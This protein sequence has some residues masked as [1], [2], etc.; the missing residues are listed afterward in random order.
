VRLNLGCGNRR[1]EGYLNLD[2]RDGWTW[3]GGLPNVAS[4]SI[5]CVTSSHTLMY[6]PREKWASVFNEIFRV[7]Q[8]GG[9]WRITEDD[10]VPPGVG[11]A[12]YVTRSLADHHLTQAG[13]T[14]AKVPRDR[15]LFHD[16]SIIQDN[17]PDELTISFWL[18]GIKPCPAK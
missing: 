4:N 15:T 5:E 16:K 2:R 9:V 7:L 13:F 17:Y 12:T 11:Y 8:P 18:E 3:E 1:L 6:V 14:V 10:G